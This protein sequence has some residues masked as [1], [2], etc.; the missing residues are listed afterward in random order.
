MSRR[1]S[2]TQI[3]KKGHLLYDQ[4]LR[5]EVETEENIGKIIVFDVE[6]G[7]F[8]IDADGIRANHR[9][10]ERFPEADPYN[11]F[12]MRIGYDAVFAIGSTITRTAAK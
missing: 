2:N 1:L 5:N 4:C 9:L 10:R 7:S 12:A 11:W 6:T 3:S 8:E